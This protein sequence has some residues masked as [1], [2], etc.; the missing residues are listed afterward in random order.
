ME[1]FKGYFPLTI[2]YNVLILPMRNGNPFLSHIRLVSLF[3]SYPTYEEW[4][5]EDIKKLKEIEDGS[6][7]TYEEW[8]P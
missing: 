4:K 1:T 2:I 3:S 6:Y 8:K 7:P 5:L